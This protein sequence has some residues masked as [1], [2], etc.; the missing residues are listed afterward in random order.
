MAAPVIPEARSIPEAIQL[1]KCLN[2]PRFSTLVPQ[3]SNQLQAL[4]LSPFGWEA[5]D[6]M[7][8]DDDASVRFYGALTFQVKL[9]KD[10]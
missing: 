10:G 2:D 7:L 8:R 3:I 5:A 6:A 9:N 4:Q 1:V